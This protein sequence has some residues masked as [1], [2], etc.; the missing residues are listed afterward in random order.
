[1][2]K[3]TRHDT[4]QLWSQVSLGWLS[5]TIS[6][7]ER[8][9]SELISDGCRALTILKVG[10][11]VHVS[12]SE[13][14]QLLVDR[15]P[16]HV[17]CPG[18]P[19]KTAS[20]SPSKPVHPRG[21]HFT[22]SSLRCLW[23][24]LACFICL[25]TH[26]AKETGEEADES[27]SGD[28]ID[29]FAQ[30][31]FLSSDV[32]LECL[33]FKWELHQPQ[34]FQSQTLAK[35]YLEAL[36][37][38]ST[39]PLT[40]LEKPLRVLTTSASSQQLSKSS[41]SALPATALG[42]RCHGKCEGPKASQHTSQDGLSFPRHA[43]RALLFQS[44]TGSWNP[45]SFPSLS[46]SPSPEGEPRRL[47]ESDSALPR[48]AGSESQLG[49]RRTAATW[50]LAHEL[51][52][53]S[54]AFVPASSRARLGSSASPVPKSEHLPGQQRK[55]LVSQTKTK[56]R[57]PVK[58]MIIS[59]KINDP[60]VTEV[61]FATALKSLCMSEVEIRLDNVLG[62]LASAH[63]LQFNGLFQRTISWASLGGRG[64]SEASDGQDPCPLKSPVR[65][66]PRHQ[67]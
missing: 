42:Y 35:L 21:P 16:G 38:G 5:E 10:T 45:W 53:S 46:P 41:P 58:K 44:Q 32:I 26:L 37:Q 11:D 30:H 64:D 27:L 29:A 39:S 18:G 23:K 59:L 25:T 15:Y 4:D 60:L 65:Q 33:G 22:A 55:A 62:V 36:A 31:Y 34:L 13:I 20:V 9:S 54:E 8:K 57:S 1:M 67:K 52:C 2:V 6:W 50:V 14:L 61:P 63:I 12:A 48:C 17:S 7:H 49:S 51:R 40:E 43:S 66:S 47:R 56:E 3:L 24:L 28:V 19:C